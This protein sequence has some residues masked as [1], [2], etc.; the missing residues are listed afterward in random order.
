MKTKEERQAR[1][2]AALSDDE[3]QQV[4]GGAE[5]ITDAEA[6]AV[7]KM[8]GGMQTKYKEWLSGKI[9]NR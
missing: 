7:E 5:A 4:S 9:Q 6:E 1:K 3:L 8:A 2:H